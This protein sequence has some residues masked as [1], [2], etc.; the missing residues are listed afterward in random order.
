MDGTKDTFDE[1][2]MIEDVCEDNSIENKK[3][4]IDEVLDS[5]NLNCLGYGYQVV[6]N[7]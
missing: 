3:E 6:I 5:L 7:K 2:G 1:N 4:K